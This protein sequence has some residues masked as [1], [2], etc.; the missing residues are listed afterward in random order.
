MIYYRKTLAIA[1]L[2]SAR[3]PRLYFASL[4]IMSGPAKAAQAL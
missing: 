3:K 1:G 2:K 4:F